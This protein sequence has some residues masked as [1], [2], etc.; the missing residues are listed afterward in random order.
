MEDLTLRDY[1]RVVFRQK[2]IILLCFFTVMVT[3]A[4]GLMLKTRV[5]KSQVKLLISG[6]KAVESPYYTD[7]GYQNMQVTLTQSE[8]VRSNPVMERA[9][10][11]LGFSQRPLDYEI[12]FCGPLKAALLGWQMRNVDA[13]LAAMDP[14]EKQ[15]M[16]YRR[17]LEELKSSIKVEP[18]RDTNIF[19]ITASDYNPIGAAIIA[20]VVSRSYLIFD[21]EQQLAELQIKYGEKH[22]AVL[23][24]RDNIE[25]MT[26][27]LNGQ[28]L[29]DIDAIGPAS[30]KIIEQASVPLSPS[31]I[32]KKL[33][34]ML[35][36]FMAIFL[37]IML[38]FAFEY[39]DQTFKN[40]MDIENFLNLPFLGSI[41]SGAKEDSYRNLSDQVYLLMKDKGL[42]SLLMASTL[43][44][45]SAPEIIANLG[46]Y[47]AERA[48]HKVLVIDADLRK[49]VIHLALN[50][51]NKAG[52][53]HT[54][55]D[56][57]NKN[58]LVDVIEGKLTFDKAAQALGP[59][60]TVLT[61]GETMLNP[62]VLLDSHATSKLFESITPKYDV[63]LVNCPNLKD[64]KDAAVISPYLDGV[65]IVINESRTRRQVVKSAIAT[66]QR[67]KANI[68]GA[69]LNNR[70]FVIPKM[71]YE[72]V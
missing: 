62:V 60:L 43:A 70:S 2:W 32:S 36:F 55:Y 10:R 42:K 18:V 54:V 11:A 61:A 21:L 41:M 31:G 56:I 24:L 67:K 69:V 23:Q 13:R 68:F 38:A 46:R 71:I 59:N 12:R 64:Y 19:T 51:R 58:G 53:V 4:M 45:E 15:A 66:L 1:L 65:I 35:A 27:G 37:S 33:T 7:I 3:V 25:K 57:T 17:A 5:Y 47:M 29:S 48:D 28:P 49:P 72:R 63:I 6:Q 14:K 39:L 34:L 26:Q 22:L 9:V 50:I 44:D 40:P 30:V 20:N 8:I 16:L 52:L